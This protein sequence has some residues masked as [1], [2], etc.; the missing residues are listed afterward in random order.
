MLGARVQVRVRVSDAFG[1]QREAPIR[2]LPDGTAVVE[3]AEAIP[4][5]RC[6]S[7]HWPLRAA[8]SAS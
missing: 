8:V 3:A 6:A 7:I 2:A 1:R 4:S 5:I